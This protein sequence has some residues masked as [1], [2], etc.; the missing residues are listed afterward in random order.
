M[1]K[2]VLMMGSILLG[3]TTCVGPA[4]ADSEPVH[5]P[6]RTT[7]NSPSLLAH[8]EE[9]AEQQTLQEQIEAKQAEDRARKLAEQQLRE[10]NTARVN[11]VLNILTDRIGKTRYVFSGSTPGGWD[12]SGLVV[13]AYGE[14]GIELEHRAS[15]Q[16]HA[17][18]QVDEPKPGD[19]VVFTYNSRK[20]AYHVGIYVDSDT[21]IHAGGGRGDATEFASISKFAGKHSTITYRRLLQTS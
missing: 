15:K 20:S 21:M 16:Q 3:L 13:W 9:A 17:G 12:C 6:K 19:I 11:G 8:I 2:H 1:K 18:V 4:S 14:L 5:S 10:H 7:I